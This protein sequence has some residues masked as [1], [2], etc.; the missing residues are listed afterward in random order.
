M[1]NEL[2]GIWYKHPSNITNS[3]LMAYMIR[4][5]GI[6]SYGLYM[7]FADMLH[8]VGGYQEYDFKK[9]SLMLGHTK[10][11][12]KA[13]LERVIN[14]YQLFE[15][16]TDDDGKEMVGLERLKE[17]IASLN[18]HKINGAKGGKKRAENYRNKSLSKDSKP[19]TQIAKETPITSVETEAPEYKI[20]SFFYNHKYRS[21]L[22]FLIKRPFSPRA[23]QQVY[24]N[25]MLNTY[26]ENKEEIENSI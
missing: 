24:K 1:N 7:Q 5:E 9:I 20:A 19:K 12:I 2:Y 16:Y 23:N 6:E 4:L 11:N 18:K 17:D 10:K 26:P 8:T 21:Q 25:Y 15:F 13:K 14:D 22:D 3:P